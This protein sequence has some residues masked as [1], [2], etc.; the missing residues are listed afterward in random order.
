MWTPFNLPQ[1]LLKGS[2]D[3]LYQYDGDQT[4]VLEVSRVGIQGTGAQK[5]TRTYYFAPGSFELIEAEEDSGKVKSTTLRHTI[6]STEGPV[7][8][9][10]LITER[11]GCSSTAP[12]R[13][14][15]DANLSTASV[16]SNPSQQVTFLFKDHLG[17]ITAEVD[18]V[19]IPQ[20]ESI[21]ARSFAEWG[22]RRHA[23]GQMPSLANPITL[24]GFATDRGFTGHEMLD[25]VGFIHMNGRIYEAVSGRFLSPDPIVQA[26]FDLQNYNR[27]SYVMNNP[28]SFTDPTGYSW[29]T[30]YRKP[31]LA[32]AA[33]IAVPMA[34]NALYGA[35]A[36]VTSGM[37]AAEGMTFLQMSS[38]LPAMG[39]MTAGT[40]A[41]AAGGFAAGGIAGGNL[42]SAVQG[43]LTSLAFSAVGDLASSHGL[44]AGDFGGASH[45]N[46]MVGHAVVGCASSAAQGGSCKSGAAS[47]AFAMFF[48]PHLSVLDGNTVGGTVAHAMLGGAGAVLGGGKFEN[49]AVTGAFGYLFN[50]I[51][52]AKR[53]EGQAIAN[54]MRMMGA[55]I[56]GMENWPLDGNYHLGFHRESVCSGPC[57]PSSYA[58]TLRRYAHPFSDGTPAQQG[59]IRFAGPGNVRTY[60][61]DSEMLGVNATIRGHRLHPGMVMRWISTDAS[62]NVYVN[63][64]GIGVGPMGRANVALM[65][66]V[67]SMT[68]VDV[69]LRAVR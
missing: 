29:W 25:E 61:S 62:G 49:G 37:A 59:E 45:V 18:A 9:V 31:I 55:Y 30:Q 14:A 13:I 64:F 27:Y 32:I 22:E 56:D 69:R 34:V 60:W 42:N 50:Q 6:G 47:A 1:R 52:A 58:Q 51:A 3:V 8:T 21:R 28:L 7:A 15:F 63:T 33:A 67:W 40:V 38:A 11:S 24:I 35:A 48:T 44:K 65:P 54:R 66:F 39:G 10:N 5:T 23:G 4:R 46:G 26:P 36:G 20:V 16:C 41:T 19:P 17:S 57:D 12:T 68:N 43:A 53:A 2:N